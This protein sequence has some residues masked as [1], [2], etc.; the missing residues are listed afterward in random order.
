MATIPTAGSN[1]G[2]GAVGHSLQALFSKDFG[3]HQFDVNE[4]IQFVG[5]PDSGGF[6]RNYFSAVDYAHPIKGNWAF[7]AEIAGTT[8]TNPTTPASMTLLGAATYNVSSRFVL[9]CGAYYSPYGNFPRVTGFAG[10]TYSIADLY[11]HRP[12]AVAPSVARH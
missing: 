11:H 7:A 5:R 8:K 3:K 6:D 1:L 9:D 10:L 12:H 4:G 2:S